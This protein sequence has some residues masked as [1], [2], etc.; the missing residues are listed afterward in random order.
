MTT[1]L[2]C[3]GF[4]TW[5]NM[6]SKTNLPAKK[7]NQATQRP[8]VR[9]NIQQH[10][11]QY[12][13]CIKHIFFSIHFFNFCFLIGSPLRGV[14]EYLAHILFLVYSC[15]PRRVS[16][17]LWT[18]YETVSCMQQLRERNALRTCYYAQASLWRQRQGLN[19]AQ[20]QPTIS[21]TLMHRF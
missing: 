17:K 6:K 8:R 16:R 21:S 2:C 4:E 20:S 10:L 9:A 11:A 3:T 15:S 18:V 12:V 7:I 13:E 5:L 1:W 14:R 19:Y